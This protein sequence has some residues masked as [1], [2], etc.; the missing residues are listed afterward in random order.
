[1]KYNLEQRREIGRRI[2][3]GELTR[4]EAAS[5]YGIGPDTARDYMRSYRDENHLPP[6][7][8]VSNI[9]RMM[10]AAAAETG[11]APKDYMSMTREELLLE[12]MRVKI[13]EARSKKGYAVKGV[14]AQKRFVPIDSSSSK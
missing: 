11:E 1:M 12:L 6:R 8:A 3:E 13:D 4:Y 5:E 2:Y 14:G 10:R 9:G 7:H